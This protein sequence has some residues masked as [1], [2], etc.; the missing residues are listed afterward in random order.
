VALPAKIWPPDHKLV[1]VD[2]GGVTDPDG[3]PVTL[4]VTAI[5]QDELPT[6]VGSGKTCPD[7]DGVGTAH[8]RV[9]AERSGPGHGRVYYISI[10]ATDTRHASCEATVRVCVPHDQGH[11]GTCRGEGPLFPSTGPCLDLRGKTDGKAGGKAG[12]KVRG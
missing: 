10:R 11:G 7:A 2:I 4:R 8:P 3:E 5:R 6:I 1:D 12:G 9:R